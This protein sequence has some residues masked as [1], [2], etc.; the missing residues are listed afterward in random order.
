MEEKY[1]EYL[2]TIWD[3]ELLKEYS[4]LSALKSS[5]NEHT[6]EEHIQEVKEKTRLVLCQME[7][8]E[9]K[10]EYEEKKRILDEN[11]TDHNY[12]NACAV[13][14]A[15]YQNKVRRILYIFREKQ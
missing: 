1:K 14:E 9:Q 7:L 12:W 6:P 10:R 4:Y 2:W 8:N 13:L 5:I 3:K 15:S 11:P